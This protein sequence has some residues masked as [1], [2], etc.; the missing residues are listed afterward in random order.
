MNTKVVFSDEIGNLIPEVVGGLGQFRSKAGSPLIVAMIGPVGSGKGKVAEF[1][2]KRFG[3]PIVSVSTAHL[4]AQKHRLPDIGQVSLLTAAAMREVLD[5][6]RA[7]ILQADHADQEK[8]DL[9]QQEEAN[10]RMARLVFIQLVISPKNFLK[11]V[12]LAYTNGHECSP[13]SK[14]TERFVRLAECMPVH[15]SKSGT[16]SFRSTPK[17]PLIGMFSRLIKLTMRSDWRRFLIQ[18]KGEIVRTKV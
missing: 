12:L 13:D 10:I 5:F 18:K 4:A 6:K 3:V 11:K 17:T 14:W 9:L 7:V 2:S 8:L 15:Y 16:V 1:L